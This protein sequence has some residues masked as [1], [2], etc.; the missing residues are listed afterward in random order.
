M[1]TIVSILLM[2][3]A[4]GAAT[5]KECREY[6]SKYTHYV[7]AFN[8]SPENRKQYPLLMVKSYMDS[9]ILECEGMIDIASYKKDVPKV[10]KL[11]TIYIP[12]KVRSYPQNK[13][14]Y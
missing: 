5:V 1:K 10:K 8:N 4:L 11:W 9:L 13:W 3:S 7:N 2:L 14:K 6:E 12:S